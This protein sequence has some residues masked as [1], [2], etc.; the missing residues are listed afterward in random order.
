MKETPQVK[1]LDKFSFTLG[2]ISICLSEW[3][4][5]RVPNM[6]QY[7]YILL[8]SLLLIY[9]YYD[10]SLIKSELYLL[11]FCYFVNLSVVLQTVYYPDNMEWF[12]ANYVLTQ[13]NIYQNIDLILLAMLFNNLSVFRAN[14]YSHSGLEEFIGFS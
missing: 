3:L 7:F 4:I 12:K 1:M 13:G 11:D 14:L 10:Y 8:M 9:R 6:F 2:V 5:L